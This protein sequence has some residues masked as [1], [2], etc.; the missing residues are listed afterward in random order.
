MIIIIIMKVIVVVV[1]KMI[2]DVN[3]DKDHS[4]P[5]TIGFYF[6]VNFFCNKKNKKQIN[7]TKVT[8]VKSNC[9]GLAV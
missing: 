8:T 6:G 5:Q 4:Q 3:D 7:N 2:V 1:E 9:P